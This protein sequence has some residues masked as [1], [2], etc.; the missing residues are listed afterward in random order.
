M[1]TAM[2]LF[3]VCLLLLLPGVVAA[4]PAQVLPMQGVP[5]TRESQVTM[6]NYRKSPMN[7]WAFRNAGAPMNVVMIPRQGDIRP[8]PGPLRPE[9]GEREFTDL[10]GRT[11]PFDALFEANYADG[12]VVVQGSRLLHENYFNGF[13]AH[14]QH[15]WF[16]MTKSLASTAFG[17]LVEQNKVDLQ[18]SPVK[19]IPELAGSGFER[20]TIQQVLDH[21][22]AIDFKENYTDENSDFLRFYAPALNM[23]WVPGAADVQPGDADIYGVHDFLVKFIKPDPAQQPGAAFDYNSSNADLLGWLIARISGQTFQ[24][25]VQQ[26]I[27]ARLGA[28][29]DAFIAVDRAYMPVVTGGMN[30]TTRDAARF[31]MMVRDRGKFA[32]EQVIPAAWIDASLDI[33]EQVRANMAANPKYGDD[34]W[35]AYH[36]MWWVLD[37]VAGEYCAVGV[38][39]QVIYINRSADTVMVWFSSQAGASAASNP[40]FHSKLKAARELAS[41]LKRRTQAG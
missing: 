22:T 13:N 4:A 28:E 33:S 15:V 31:G 32:G 39:G 14:A 19:Y 16:S 17:L 7:Q 20:V 9:L 11:L 29:H 38:H 41:S 36:N 1:R 12:V 5:P 25:Y 10:H 34:P 27:W 26:N 2:A 35:V 3:S 30:T 24:D 40:N 18:A 21:A 37:E 8:L 23:A 6:A